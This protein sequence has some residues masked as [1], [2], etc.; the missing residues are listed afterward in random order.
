MRSTRCSTRLMGSQV[1]V[2]VPFRAASPMTGYRSW[3]LTSALTAVAMALICPVQAAAQAG[4]DQ[5]AAAFART[6]VTPEP[7]ILL[8]ADTLNSS[9]DGESVEAT[10]NV[11]A[12]SQGRT[13]SAER[14]T[15]NRVTGIVEAFGGITIIEANGVATFADSITVDDDL[16]TGIIRSFSARLPEGAVLAADAAIRESATLTRLSRVIYTACPL[17]EDGTPPTWAIRARRAVQNQDAGLISYSDVVVEVAGVPVGYLPYL[18]HPDPSAKRKS[19]LLPAFP[20]NNS[21]L[22]INMELPYLFV[23]DDHSDLTVSPLISQYINPVLQLNYRRA[24]HSGLFQI[25]GSGTY[26]RLFGNDSDR[27]GDRTFRG[28]AFGQGAF[29]LNETWRWG[30]GLETA[31]DDTYLLRYGFR[32]EGRTRGPIRG[33]SGRLISQV[34]AEAQTETIF[35]RVFAA[36]LQDLIGGTRRAETPNVVPSAEFRQ[37]LPTSFLN[38]MVDLHANLTVLERREDFV[39]SVRLNAGAG[40]RGSLI[41]DRGVI[42]EPHISVR[43]D[44]FRYQRKSV[45]DEDFGRALGQVGVDVRWPLQRPEANVT[46]ELEPR[47]S[48]VLASDAGNQKG[49]I[50]EDTI[51]YELGRT[52]LFGRN[53]VVGQDFWQSGPRLTAGISGAGRFNNG[54]L[55][56]GFL[57]VQFRDGADPAFSRSTNLDRARSDLIGEYGISWPELGSIRARLRYDTELDALVRTEAWITMKAWRFDLEGRYLDSSDKTFGPRYGNREFEGGFRYR[58]NDDWQLFAASLYNFEL[59]QTLLGRMGAVFQDDC[60]ELRIFYERSAARN[61]FVEPSSSFRIQV[62]FRTFG[63]LGND[64]TDALW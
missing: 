13:I 1:F 62:A 19:G 32:G 57:G 52:G 9:P 46:W 47:A 3:L 25:E 41:F 15:Y 26:E 51:G 63:T 24:F 55:V 5:T 6:I 64:L 28:H 34:F 45:P 40:W 59:D 18:A 48:F 36:G 7:G 43:A 4:G 10:G 31:S 29:K 16:A 61:R 20:S 58:L 8:E 38:G 44:Q 23:L 53:E 2:P 17:C 42:M 14:V 35:A 12:R 33:E 60:T 27:F 49:I 21:R 22:G 50:L 30:F 54:A 56:E 39:D 37:H 11:I